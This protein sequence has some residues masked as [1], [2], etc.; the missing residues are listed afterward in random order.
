MP[1]PNVQA[2]V[3]E[4]LAVLKKHD[5]AGTCFISS[6]SH[7]HYLHHM[8]ATWSCIY[9]IED[10]KGQGV[11]FRIQRSEFPTDEAY[12]K[13]SE[14]SVGLLQGTLDAMRNTSEVYTEILTR[15]IAHGWK[16][17]HISKDEGPTTSPPP[18]GEPRRRFNDPPII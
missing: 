1:D 11:R 18:A 2:A 15:L 7:V 16:W 13:A 6:Q 9:F 14:D 12:K 4:I 3:D 8:E 17:D 5:L 10:A